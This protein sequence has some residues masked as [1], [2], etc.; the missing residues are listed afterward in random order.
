MLRKIISSKFFSYT[1]M[2]KFLG[3]R[4]KLVHDSIKPVS[5]HPASKTKVYSH[6]IERRS[7]DSSIFLHSIR[8]PQLTEEQIEII[9]SGGARDPFVVKQAGSKGSKKK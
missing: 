7:S 3:P 8:Y 9:N 6:T 5:Q 2:I 1:P 4:A